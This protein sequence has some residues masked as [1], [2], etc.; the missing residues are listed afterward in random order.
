M[1]NIH[2][3][4]GAF[5]SAIFA[6]SLFFVSSC[7]ENVSIPIAEEKQDV[8]KLTTTLTSQQKQ[9]IE[10][11]HTIIS[12]YMKPLMSKI[13]EPKD[14][15]LDISSLASFVNSEL[16]KRKKPL[17]KF[18]T[19]Q[20]RQ[21]GKDKS[22]SLNSGISVYASYGG[23][24]YKTNFAVGYDMNDHALF[25]YGFA[26]VYWYAD[27]WFCQIFAGSIERRVNVGYGPISVP[28]S[29]NPVSIGRENSVQMIAFVYDTQGN[30]WA[31]GSE[32]VMYGFPPIFW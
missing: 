8:I 30:L 12:E 2:R 21:T 16:A 14:N 7:Q 10:E 9:Q 32:L 23:Y 13:K 27:Y 5:A 15:N 29:Y 19:S 28:I 25:N 20:P 26:T 1:P 6:V 11:V 22:A 4:R 31:G 3:I 17:V 24:G 18:F